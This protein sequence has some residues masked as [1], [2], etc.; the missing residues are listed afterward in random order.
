MCTTK[1]S[2]KGFIDSKQALLAGEG[3]SSL[4]LP[5]P[6][7]VSTAKALHVQGIELRVH[8][9]RGPGFL[10][11]LVLEIDSSV[12]CSRVRDYIPTGKKEKQAPWEL[13]S[14]LT[15]V[16]AHHLIPQGQSNSHVA[17]QLAN[18]VS[19]PL[20]GIR[21]HKKKTNHRV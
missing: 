13:Q 4:L 17:R 21:G 15:Q 5:S 16:S 7:E 2:S 9:I 1:L 10:E 12:L 14:A 3:D 11:D 20:A 8:F 6:P 18:I 19:P